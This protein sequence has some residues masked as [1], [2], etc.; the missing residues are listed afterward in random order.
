M[1]RASA[2]TAGGLRSVFL[3]IFVLMAGDGPSFEVRAATYCLND[4]PSM[5]ASMLYGFCLHLPHM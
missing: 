1:T 3:V 5:D 4:V 2:V